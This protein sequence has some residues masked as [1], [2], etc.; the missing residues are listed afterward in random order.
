MGKNYNKYYNKNRNTEDKKDTSA[1]VE[2]KEEIVE[3]VEDK[4]PP[5]REPAKAIVN[6]DCLNF[7]AKPSK[8]AEILAILKKDGEIDL[9][10][11]E[12]D[13]AGWSY[14]SVDGKLGYVM[15]EFIDIKR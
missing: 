10:S 8:N 6:V 4:E 11:K 13:V 3:K 15:T 7:R 2:N 9:L 1:E 12:T 5:T 14:V